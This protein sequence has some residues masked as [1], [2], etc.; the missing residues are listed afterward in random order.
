MANESIILRAMCIE[1]DF[2]RYIVHLHKV[3]YHSTALNW[4][5]LKWVSRNAV[6]VLSSDLKKCIESFGWPQ[7]IHFKFGAFEILQ[8]LF[9]TCET[10]KLMFCLYKVKSIRN[11]LLHSMDAS[12]YWS[13]VILF[14]LDSNIPLLYVY[15][16]IATAYAISIHRKLE[17][18][19]SKREIL[20]MYTYLALTYSVP[21][22]CVERTNGQCFYEIYISHSYNWN[23][24]KL[25]LPL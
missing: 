13:E 12:S 4:F 1:I 6:V 19:L 15:I 20:S 10:W 21:K 14:A 22:L 24:L 8:I 11:V 3:G 25:H 2:K 5:Y 9:G 18:K 7:V 23:Q 16:E 17:N